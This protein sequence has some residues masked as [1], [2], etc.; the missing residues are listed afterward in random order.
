[1]NFS[2]LIFRP[3]LAAS[4]I[5]SALLMFAFTASANAD[6]TPCQSGTTTWTAGG[7]GN[8]DITTNWSN[9]QPSGSCNTVIAQPVTVTLSTTSQHFGNDDGVGVNGVALSNGATLVV[10]G[11]S[12]DVQ[13]NWLNFT[14]LAIGP[15]GLTIA[16][17]STLDLEASDDTQTPALGAPGGNA[18]VIMQTGSSV[19]FVNA[20]TINATSTDSKYSDDL[21]FGANLANA[22]AINAT[23]GTLN[24]VGTSP[25]L[26]NNTGSV[27]VAPG[28]SVAMNAGDG[29]AFTN[30]LGGT[31]ANQ[32]S[33]TLT[34]SMHF[35]QSGGT[36][37]GDPIE[38]TG[39]ETLED[40]A[41]TGA[42]E[43]IDG[44]GGGSV[45]GTIPQ[46]QTIT[47]QGA[48]QNC[49]GNTGQT[50]AMTLGSTAS[51]T[52]TNHGTIVLSASGSG[53]T[54]GGSAQITGG[55]LDNFGTLN[56]TVSDT[57][58]T[59]AVLSPLI[60]EKGATVNLTGG[61]LYQSAGTATTN[62]GTVNVGPGGFWQVQ[63]GS[64]NNS[65]TL[66]L[67]I[68]SKK[69]YG[70]FNLT[71][72]GA[73]K[74]GGTLA[75]TLSGYKPATGTELP[76]FTLNGGPFSG[77]FKTVSNGFRGDYSK[78]TKTPAS[79][80]VIYGAAKQSKVTKVSGG[81][82][83]VTVKLSCAKGKGCAT[84][85]ITVTDG[86]TKVASGSATV[87][88]G[89][90]ATATVKLNAAGR[91]LIKKKTKVKVVVKAAGKTLKTATVTVTK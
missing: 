60:N 66:A 85:S 17:G 45:T 67:K 15:A 74:A 52:V 32:G 61:K 10:R 63:G 65:G 9:G 5:S 82:G 56:A 57:N 75:P 33:T 21:R 36:E 80:D 30:A 87:K 79:V 39:G 58:Y 88:A 49:S 62:K 73:F 18:L 34:S 16:K 37:T 1:M 20:G 70:V 53:N 11:E 23:S 55:T 26:V 22:G 47:V 19:P 54:T 25:M 68:A 29:S 43:V 40:S 89:K 3:R 12:S 7:S 84:D 72:G 51:P 35:I 77:T 81:S 44:C 41:G 83:K 86:K 76:L 71:A 28:A 50:S 2:H 78:E 6:F 31:F 90:S 46:G 24:F 64:F 27:N 59:T 38:M 8:W 48:T 91:K 14:Q 69:S 4:L 42:F 13:G